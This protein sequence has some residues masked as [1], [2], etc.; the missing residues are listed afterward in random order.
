MILG[1]EN[2][3]AKQLQVALT[4]GSEE[5]QQQA[6][7]DFSNSIVE[8]IKADAEIYA[9]TGDKNILAQRGYRQ[10]TSAE[11]RFYDKFIE[12]SKMRN[13][14][15]AVT[16]LKDLKDNELMPETIIED[17]YRD[18]VAEH[19]LLAKVKLFNIFVAIM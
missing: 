8:S 2:K 11:E 17:V 7:N 6:W 13:V 10:L 15:M 3:Y 19:P 16:T 5:E 1:N 12:A 9:Q 14:Q 18:L 4:S